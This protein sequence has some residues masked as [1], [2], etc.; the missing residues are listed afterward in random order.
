MNLQNHNLKFVTRRKRWFLHFSCLFGKKT[1]IPSNFELKPSQR[2]RFWPKFIKKCQ[3]LKKKHSKNPVLNCF[4]SRENDRFCNFRPFLTSNVWKIGSS[5]CAR[6]SE[7]IVRRDRFWCNQLKTYQTLKKMLL[8]KSQFMKDATP[9]KWW[10]L[11]F[12][13]ILEKHDLKLEILR[14]VSFWIRFLYIVSNFE[15]FFL[16]VVGTR[17]EDCT[18]KITL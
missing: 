3:N 10:F 16:K 4:A 8:S 13:C 2:F 7:T 5:W 1:Y 9:K 17:R 11:H 18:L 15:F 12:P 6:F 14:R